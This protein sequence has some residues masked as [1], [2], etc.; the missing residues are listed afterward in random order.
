MD[1]PKQSYSIFV[2]IHILQILK[3]IHQYHAKKEL[4]PVAYQGKNDA[5]H[6]DFTHSYH[7]HSYIK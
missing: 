5:L 2:I 1:F 7:N 6:V 4:P 3:L